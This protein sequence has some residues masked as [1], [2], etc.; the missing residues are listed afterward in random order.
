VEQE[1]GAVGREGEI[2]A[3]LNARFSLSAL[4]EWKRNAPAWWASA[5]NNMGRGIH[6]QALREQQRLR[7]VSEGD[8]RAE[9]AAIDRG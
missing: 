3:I 8:I 4:E 2:L 6:A 1:V 5:R 9:L 7:T